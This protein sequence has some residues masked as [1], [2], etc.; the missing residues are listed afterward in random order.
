MS[1]VHDLVWGVGV[2]LAM[3]LVCVLIHYEGLNLLER[4]VRLERH[5][6]RARLRLA[7]VM[8]CVVLLHSA[9]IWIFAALYL[10]MENFP[11]LGSLQWAQGYPS[12]RSVFLDKLYYSAVVYTSLGFGDLVPTGALRIVST[13]ETLLGLLLI[14]W[15][16]SFTYLLM[17][18][19]WGLKT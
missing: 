19:L 14:A 16:A 1:E 6:L 9:E 3:A 18:R 8:A 13:T 7:G 15:S 10:G 2:S 11:A 4:I 12:E 5:W 17:Q